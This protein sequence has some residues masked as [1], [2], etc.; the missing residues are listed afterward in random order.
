MKYKKRMN[1]QSKSCNNPSQTK[2]EA[3]QLAEVDGD[4]FHAHLLCSYLIWKCSCFAIC[5]LPDAECVCFFFFISKAEPANVLDCC[6]MITNK[7]ISNVENGKVRASYVATIYYA[8]SN[9]KF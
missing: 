1:T 3:I 6:N 9:I 4:H 5:P 8:T 2:G 7:V